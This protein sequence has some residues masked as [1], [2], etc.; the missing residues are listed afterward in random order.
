MSTNPFPGLRPF[1]SDEYH[2]FFGREEQTTALLSLLR[3]QRFLAVVGTSGSG[4][5]S[6]VRAGLIPALH[7]GAM[8]AT[9]SH[10]E[11]AVTRPGGDPFGSLAQ[12][13][14]DA[15]LYDEDDPETLPR[16]RATLSHSDKG[17]AE[18]IRQSDAVDSRTRVFLLVD[19]FEELFRFR[20]RGTESGNAAAAF[21]DL[22]LTASESSENVFVAITM[23]SDY[24]GDCSQIPG[25]AEAVNRGEYLIPRLSRDQR[26]DAIEKPINVGGAQIAPGLVEAMLNSVGDDAD[27]L[28]VLQH[29]LMRTWDV[30]AGDRAEGEGEDEE[31]GARHFEATGGMDE[32][33]S[34]HADEVFEALPSDEHRR[35]CTR[36]FRALTERGSDNRGI[37]RPTRFSELERIAR[38]DGPLIERVLDGYRAPGVTLL[39]PGV[40]QELGAETVIDLSHESLMRGWRRLR[41]WVEEES[42]SARIFTRLN[43]TA[44]LWREEKA[45]LYRDPDLRIA[46]TWRADEQPNAEWAAQ[47]GGDFETAVAFLER[48]AEAVEAERRAAEAAR[49]R[50]LEQARELAEAQ[51]LR[52]EEQQRAAGR[53]RWLVAASLV[54]AIAAFVAFLMA[55]SARREADEEKENAEQAR[56]EVS[57]ER[58]NVLR[59]AD[60]KRLEDLNTEA[61]E[62][63]PCL[64]ENAPGMR[65]W[66]ERSVN[67]LT[68]LPVHEKTLAELREAALPYDEATR[69][70]NRKTHPK[71]TE[72]AGLVEERSQL[73]AQAAEIEKEFPDSKATLINYPE[74]LETRPLTVYFRTKFE[75]SNTASI[76]QLELELS[77]DDGAL[78]Y[79]NG[80]EILR[81]NLPEGEVT[82]TTRSAGIVLVPA[83]IRREIPLENTRHLKDGTNVLAVEVHQANATSSDLHLELSL[84]VTRQEGGEPEVLIQPNG[85]WRYLDGVSSPLNPPEGTVPA[86]SA[87][88][89]SDFEDSSWQEG[90]APLGYGFKSGVGRAAILRHRIA[91]LDQEIAELDS[92]VSEQRIWK[93]ASDELDWQHGTLSGLVSGLGGFSATVA[94]VRKRLELSESIVKRSIGDHRAAW[95]EAIRSIANEEECPVYRGLRIQ[96]QVGLVPIG[97]D[98]DSGLW[99]FAHLQTGEIP[100][101]DPSTKKLVLTEEMGIV[102]VLIPGGT[103]TMGVAKPTEERPAGSP[104]VDPAAVGQEGPP[105]EVTLAPYLI[106][107]YEM[108][109]GQ[110]ERFTG[111][112]PSHYPGP[113]RGQTQVGALNPV[114][115]V[116]WNE[117][118]RELT[119]LHLDIPTEA[120]WEYAARAG[121]QSVWWLG[122][123]KESLRGVV[124][125]ADKAAIDADVNWESLSDWPDND[126][127]F[128]I[129]APVGSYGANPWGL[130]EVHGNI[131]EWCRDWFGSY[132]HGVREGSGERMVPSRRQGPR[133]RVSRGGS[134]SAVAR[135][136]RSAFRFNNAPSLR[137]ENLGVR[138]SKGLITE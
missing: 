70:E 56:I 6:L 2:L 85:R 16:L 83:P 50:E 23:R 119:R 122:N 65:A 31:I 24:L 8:A 49:A 99:E 110:W 5:S 63:W 22:L 12:A 20:E 104:N 92:E 37:R 74:D 121:T 41:D 79:L 69:E 135:L 84:R 61:D 64:P 57:E 132:S 42:Q 72:L 136:V 26:R 34:R 114:E 106:S 91:K 87:W 78:I 95:D 73:D 28:P 128:V 129:H 126:D 123:E 80:V 47:Y 68:R 100:A 1:R 39:M 134:Y 98:P 101:R 58:D 71:A 45:G 62:L 44:G 118:Q 117:C 111:D 3:E 10:W 60:V 29:A 77:V 113:V 59:L 40:E 32:A 53:L 19:Q 96:E 75:V 116:G 36:I 124:N 88:R 11:V 109:Q 15:D 108:T 102:L 21:V 18:A 66:L 115:L 13:L 76:T 127:G 67:L 38:A 133:S 137:S 48:S 105:H 138:P 89:Q 7:R 9:G 130:H 125:I 14:V 86:P 81:E 103:F 93:F 33:L 30:W 17:L 55:Q 97:R 51:K 52:A 4:K 82:A 27:Q 43:D 131:R 35:V 25:L 107:K 46:L 54:M 94:D 112:N 120:Q 90:S